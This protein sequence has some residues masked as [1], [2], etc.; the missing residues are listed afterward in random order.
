MPSRPRSIR[1]E[2]QLWDRFEAILQ[3]RGHGENVNEVVVA[4]IE[5]FVETEETALDP[6]A[7]SC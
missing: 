2:N 7:G 4:L 6:K 5:E 1:A 3:A